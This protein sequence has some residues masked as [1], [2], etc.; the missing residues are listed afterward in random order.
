MLPQRE[1]LIQMIHDALA[2]HV[3]L[4][5][6][7][8]LVIVSANRAAAES[9]GLTKSELIGRHCYE[10]WHQRSSACPDCPI[11]KTFETGF[12]QSGVVHTPDGRS[13][14][15][16]GVPLRAEDGQ[17]IGVVEVTRDITAEL[18]MRN[19]LEEAKSRAE[20]FIDLMAH[21]LNN[22]NQGILLSL[23]LLAL[24]PQMTPNLS[25]KIEQCIEQVERGVSLIAKVRRLSHIENQPIMLHQHSISGT[26]RAAQQMV[27]SSFPTRTLVVRLDV[28][29]VYD[30]VMA[31]EFLIDAFVNILNN[32]VKHSRAEPVEVD[33]IAKYHDEHTIEIRF[34]DNGPGIDEVHR[35]S[36]MSRLSTRSTT[37]GGIGLTLVQ[38]ICSRYGGSM[39]IED[40]VPGSPQQGTAVVLLLRAATVLPATC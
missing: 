36:I 34:E 23:E 6:S 16:R 28:P 11:L 27:S 20:L 32:A 7:R 26:V 33:V 40:R 8:E 3:I 9:L 35:K 38:R 5:T 14:F 30:H 2:E 31:D 1:E 13:W 19:A 21:D 29:N 39:K 18:R 25:E 4:Y 10:L 17:L 22:I 24:D 37:G 15:I 12:S